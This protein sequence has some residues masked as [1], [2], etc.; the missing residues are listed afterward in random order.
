MTVYKSCS[1][2]SKTFLRMICTAFHA[3]LRTARNAKRIAKQGK[4]KAV[5][6]ET[7]VKGDDT[8]TCSVIEG[9]HVDRRRLGRLWTV[10]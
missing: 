7:K 10:S 5:K 8:R 6:R 2:A 3:G 9:V 1:K 4:S